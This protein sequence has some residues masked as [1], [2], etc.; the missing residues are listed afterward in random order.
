VG[1]TIRRRR[2]TR[3]AV[4]LGLPLLVAIAG[5]GSDEGG[6]ADDPTGST[7]DAFCGYVSADLARDVLGSEDL[8]AQGDEIADEDER[9]QAQECTIEPTRPV[10]EYIAIRVTEDSGTQPAKPPLSKGCTEPTLPGGWSGAA[11]WSDDFVELISSPG[12]GR[13]IVITVRP[14]A[15]QVD[16]PAVVDQAASIAVDVNDHIETHDDAAA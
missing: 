11:C 9:R 13:L 10:D 1:G 16:S 8:E 3:V 4:A 5:C 6:P 7:Q 15:A 12:D 2:S 14:D